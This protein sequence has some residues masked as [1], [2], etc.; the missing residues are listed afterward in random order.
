VLDVGKLPDVPL[1]ETSAGGRAQVASFIAAVTDWE[2]FAASVATKVL[3][4]NRPKLIP[5]FD[6]E[7]IFGAYINPNGP[8]SWHQ[9]TAFTRRHVSRDDSDL[10]IHAFRKPLTL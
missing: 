3:R 1:E 6:H 2:G 7:A 9:P 4:K 10:L 5:I 8:K